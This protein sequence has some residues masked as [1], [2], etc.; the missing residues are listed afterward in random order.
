M[1]ISESQLVNL[2]KECYQEVVQEIG[3]YGIS[4]HMDKG[5][6]DLQEVDG[7]GVSNQIDNVQSDVKNN[8]KKC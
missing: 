6:E 1:R 7:Y 4:D 3:G 2:I 8:L 5:E